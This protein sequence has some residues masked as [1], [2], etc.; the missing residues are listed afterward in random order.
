MA[1]FLQGP[2]MLLGPVKKQ[3]QNVSVIHIWTGDLHHKY[4]VMLHTTD[5]LQPG[6]LNK[7]K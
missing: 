1:D 6:K 7:F 2:L 3:G 5:I 4:K